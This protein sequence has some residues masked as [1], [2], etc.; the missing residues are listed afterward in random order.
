[1]T[2][3]DVMIHGFVKELMETDGLNVD[4]ARERL[5]KEVDTACDEI[6]YG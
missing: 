6:A 2:A 5:Q 4:E 1:M 3:Y